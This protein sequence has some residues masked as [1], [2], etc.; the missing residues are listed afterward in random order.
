LSYQLSLH[1]YSNYFCFNE[2]QTPEKSDIVKP[3]KT[4][5]GIISI[6]ADDMGTVGNTQK[7]V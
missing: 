1:P 2:S 5:E 4:Q 6:P 7:A 3:E